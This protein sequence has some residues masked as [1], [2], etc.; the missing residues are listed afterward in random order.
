M[1]LEER[2]L[3]LARQIGRYTP[4]PAYAGLDA[5]DCTQEAIIGLLVSVQRFD[6]G[7]DVPLSAYARRRMRGAVQDAYR[8]LDPVHRSTLD[9]HSR[10]VR[11]AVVAQFRQQWR[12]AAEVRQ[13]ALCPEDCAAAQERA[14]LVQRAVETLPAQMQ[15]VLAGYYVEDLSPVVIGERMGL[16]PARIM[17]IHRQAKTRL[18]WLLRDVAR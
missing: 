17:Q 6:A 11:A 16:S 5:D 10:E 8:R 1:V 3:T 15:A 12:W 18:R 13:S 4:V 9:N 2:L 7:K 14:A